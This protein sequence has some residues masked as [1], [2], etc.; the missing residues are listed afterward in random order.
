MSLC[1]Q[2]PPGSRNKNSSSQLSIFSVRDDYRMNDPAGKAAVLA[3]AKGPFSGRE[4][5]LKKQAGAIV[6]KCFALLVLLGAAYQAMAWEATT[7][8]PNMA[9]IEQYLMTDRDAEIPLARSAA[10]ESIASD[11]ENLTEFVVAVQRWSDGTEGRK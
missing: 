2:F 3:P 9:P 1:F 4:T 5:M 6:I 7:P 11:A 10:P 8:Y